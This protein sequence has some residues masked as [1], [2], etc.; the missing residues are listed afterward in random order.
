MLQIC[1]S[2]QA[3]VTLWKLF[4]LELSWAGTFLSWLCVFLAFL[5]IVQERPD[6]PVQRRRL[7]EEFLRAAEVAGS[8]EDSQRREALHLQGEELWQEVHHR[9]K[10]K[11]PQAHTHRWAGGEMD[12]LISSEM[13]QAVTGRGHL[14]V[15]CFL[16][17]IKLQIWRVS[18]ADAS[19]SLLHLI[20]GDI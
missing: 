8:H 2:L 17:A 18:S 19:V 7:R 11:E 14:L 1:L 10:F 5:P 16:G 3:P 20:Q 15:E 13:L 12:V 9:W 4:M 6:V